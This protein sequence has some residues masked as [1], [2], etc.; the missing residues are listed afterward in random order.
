MATLAFTSAGSKVFMA[1]G[2]PTTEDAAGYNALTW[3]EIK[4]ITDV[5]LVG[6]EGSVIMH[7]PVAE[8]VTYKL[9]GSVNNGVLSLKGARAPTDPGQALL[10]LAQKNAA[11]LKYSVQV[12]LV[13]QTKIFAGVLVTSYKTSIGGQSQITGFESNLEISGGIVEA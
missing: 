11:T 4:E 6:P 2:A 10:I 12:R 7:N 3:V 9:I 1:A 5:G 13:D 8:N